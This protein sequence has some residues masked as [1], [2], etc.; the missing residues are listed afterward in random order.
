MRERK[1]VSGSF[2]VQIRTIVVPTGP[3]Q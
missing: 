2:A 3:A 1:A